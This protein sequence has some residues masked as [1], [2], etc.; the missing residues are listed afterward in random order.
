MAFDGQFPGE[1]PPQP[2]PRRSLRDRWK[3]L[4]N[5]LLVDVRFQR[6]AV[7]F[8]LTRLIAR[9]RARELFDIAAGFVYSQVLLACVQL[10]LFEALAAGPR[11][12]TDLAEHL[13]LP[14]AGMR[15]LLLAA[16][17]LHLVERRGKE[18]YGL[19]ELGAAVLGNPGIGAMV[20]HHTRLYA[21]L[22][23]PVALLRGRQDTLLSRYWAYASADRPDELDG[24]QVS[25]YSDLMAASQAF[26]AG[27]I[28]DAYSLREHKSLLD[29]GGGDGA[30]A[31]AA[32]DRWP[33]LRVALFDLPAVAERANAR[34][35]RLGLVKRAR[36]IGGDLFD[37]LLPSGH[38]LISLVRVVHDHDDER[39][40]RILRAAHAALRPGGVLLIAEPMAGTHGAEPVG[41]AYFGLYLLAMGSGRPRTRTELGL[42]LRQVGFRRVREARTL[43]PLL[44]RVLVAVA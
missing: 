10:R 36:A 43:Q 34:F 23:D 27:D 20:S 24:A 39:V 6:W 14:P 44:V 21:D 13:G 31:A 5:R 41:E 33:H 7:R 9:R 29:L 4:R 28:L 11:S 38:D 25:E 40:I 2:A 17:T 12:L 30:F 35:A 19:G 3:D 1:M 37:P 26:I 18:R 32:A 22:A 8:P 42:L 15:R 16:E